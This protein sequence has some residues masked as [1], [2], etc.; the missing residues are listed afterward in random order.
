VP[1]AVFLS[2][3]VASSDGLLG[4]LN[5]LPR[6]PRRSLSLP[7]ILDGSSLG[8]KIGTWARCRLHSIHGPS[9]GEVILLVTGKL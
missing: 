3:A 2:D 5:V 1:G 6:V 9:V 7:R 8:S 4:D